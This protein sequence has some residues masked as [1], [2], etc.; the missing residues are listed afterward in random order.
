MGASVLARTTL[1][2]GLKRSCLFTRYKRT[3]TVL[4]L[5]CS[6]KMHAY[7]KAAYTFEPTMQR[8]PHGL[9]IEYTEIKIFRVTDDSIYPFRPSAIRSSFRVHS[10]LIF[11]FLSGSRFDSSRMG[12]LIPRPLSGPRFALPGKGGLIPELLSGPRCDPSRRKGV[13]AKLLSSPRGDP[14]LF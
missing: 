4:F 10:G 11:G 12:G 5:G 7:R 14:S 9:P 6:V 2:R 13:N 8:L 3:F 1:P